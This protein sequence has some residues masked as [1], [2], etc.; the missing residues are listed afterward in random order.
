LLLATLDTRPRT[1]RFVDKSSSYAANRPTHE[2]KKRNLFGAGNYANVCL[3][4][5]A[6]ASH[7]EEGGGTVFTD[8]QLDGSDVS[9]Q[10][11]SFT[12]L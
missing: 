6:P 11:N 3:Y 7:S 9:T 8:R 12:V 5:A 1:I 10:A 4:K 2:G